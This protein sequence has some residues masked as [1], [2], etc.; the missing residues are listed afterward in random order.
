LEFERLS[1]DKKKPK[2]LPPK[3]FIEADAAIAAEHQK[4]CDPLNEILNED[5]RKRLSNR[6]ENED[7]IDNILSGTTATLIIQTQKKLYIGWVGDSQ[8]TIWGHSRENQ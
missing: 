6:D 1:K 8:V 3:N 4:D 5:M 7:A 2:E